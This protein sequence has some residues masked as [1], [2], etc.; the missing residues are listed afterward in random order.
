M[1]SVIHRHE[2]RGRRGRTLPAH[3]EAKQN[4]TTNSPDSLFFSANHYHL[5]KCYLG[6]CTLA[7]KE[8]ASMKK[9]ARFCFLFILFIAITFYANILHNY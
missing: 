1:L 8:Y 6:V 7:S 3:L 5:G 4:K 9:L 2:A